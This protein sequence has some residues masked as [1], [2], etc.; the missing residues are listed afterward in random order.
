MI[1]L[2]CLP[3]LALGALLIAGLVADVAFARG[4]GSHGGRT[5]GHMARAASGTQQRAADPPAS[6][7][8]KTPM[9][10]PATVPSTI[11]FTGPPAP[12]IATP[13]PVSAVAA[14]A[15]HVTPVAPL[16]PPVTT[17]VLTAG[18]NARIDSASPSST[19]PTEAAPDVAGGGGKSLAD[20]MG[21]WEQA[22]HMS[23]SEWRA[24]CDRSQHR[25][26]ALNGATKPA[27]KK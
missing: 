5:Y 19:S 1:N 10:S 16:S 13:A 27:H 24:S 20:C 8:A 11:L 18:G 23:K 14:P 9:S 2:R 12:S 7:T 25:L 21:F 3:L 17:T 26:E 6:T 15:L 22:T 4:G